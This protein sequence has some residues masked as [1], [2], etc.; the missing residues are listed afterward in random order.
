ME[1]IIKRGRILVILGAL[2]LVLR[3]AFMFLSFTVPLRFAILI[4]V[5]I[6]GI[7]LYRGNKMAIKVVAVYLF[8]IC[9]TLALTILGSI[10]GLLSRWESINDLLLFLRYSLLPLLPAGFTCYV[11]FFNKSAQAFLMVQ[12]NRKLLAQYPKRNNSDD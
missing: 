8:I 6:T 2:A 11:V 7:F 1:K 9:V 5:V 12:R 4:F 10:E 3:P